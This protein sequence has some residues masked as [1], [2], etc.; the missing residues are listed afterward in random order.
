MRAACGVKPETILFTSRLSLTLDL[1]QVSGALPHAYAAP[2]RPA[3]GL[4][5]LSPCWF[6][7]EVELTAPEAQGREPG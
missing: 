4:R 5:F 7:D 2:R 6:V 3:I 1:S